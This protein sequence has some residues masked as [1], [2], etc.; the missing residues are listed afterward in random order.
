VEAINRN[1][2]K[3]NSAS[4]WPYCTD[5]AKRRCVYKT[6]NIE[7][8]DFRLPPR[9]SWKLRSSELSTKRVVVMSYRRFGTTHWSYPQGS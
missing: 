1:E 7:L 5:I 8:R 2:L 6:Q 9:S 4:C 3:A